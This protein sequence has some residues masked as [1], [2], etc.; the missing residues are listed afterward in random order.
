M[1]KFLK[2]KNNITQKQTKIIIE[3]MKKI[4]DKPAAC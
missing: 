1:K 2:L 4:N 3:L